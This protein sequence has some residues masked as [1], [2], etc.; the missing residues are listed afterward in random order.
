MIYHYQAADGRMATHEQPMDHPTPP[1]AEIVLEDGTVARRVFGARPA[2]SPSGW[3]LV[4]YASGVHP[5]QA[6]ALRDEFKRVG[7]P[8]EVNKNGDPIY[9]SPE[10][11]RKALKARGMF[12]RSSYL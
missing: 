11:R 7:V 9:T 5:E 10:H 4:C 1:P 6:Q 8:T 12:D 3:P 2:A